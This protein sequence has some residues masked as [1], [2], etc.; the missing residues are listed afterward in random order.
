[1]PLAAVMRTDDLSVAK[2]KKILGMKNGYDIQLIFLGDSLTRRWEDNPDLWNKY[3]SS[4]RAANF[5]VGGDCL[6]NIK[7]RILNGELDGIDPKII[8]LLAGTNN[9]D[10][11]S[12][13]AIV[14]GIREIAVIIRE[15][16]KNTKIVILGLLPRNANETG[17]NYSRKIGRINI[18]LE[19][20]FAN[21]GMAYRDI[22][23][24]LRNEQGVVSDAIMPDGLHLNSNGYEIIGPKLRGII[25]ELW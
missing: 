19:S 11:D 17:I 2:H 22:G 14:N 20:L 15:K 16:L 9:L 7:W 10:K 1:M 8:I 23:K 21:T 6:E 5:G 18:Q 4:Y 24:D 13:E 3:F 25:D 12:E